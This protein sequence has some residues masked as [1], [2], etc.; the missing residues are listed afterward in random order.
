MTRRVAVTG[1]GVICSIGSTTAEFWAGCQ[2]GTSNV[3]P[4]PERWL[5]YADYKSRIWSPLPDIDYADRDLSRIEQLQ[6]DPV[7]MLALCASQEALL[8]AGL[9]LTIKDKRANSYTID[10]IDPERAGVFMGTGLGGSQSFL[11]SHC[12]LVLARSR[13]KLGAVAD[14]DDLEPDAR[15]TISDIVGRMIHPPRVHRFVV[16]M[17]MPN[18][19]AAMLGLKYTING[20]VVANCGACASGTVAIGNAFREVKSGTVDVALTG[21]AE[22][23]YDPYG[24]HFRC[25]DVAGT[26]VQNWDPPGQAN[27]PFDQARSGFLFSQGGAGVI[28]LEELQRALDRGAPILAEIVGYGETFDAHSIMSLDPKG[29]QIE[30][31][32]RAAISEAGLDPGDIQYINAHGT[33]TRNNDP[34]EA[35]VLKR[36]F[37]TAPLVNSTKSLLG[38]TIG[39][40]GALEAIVTA[41]TINTGTPHVCRNLDVP[42][43][44]INFVRSPRPADIAVGFTESFAFGGHN[45]GLVLRRVD[46]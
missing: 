1:T 27:R 3:A 35:E 21:G 8:N 28:V 19:V 41:L 4:I 26:L 38:H 2:R 36:V 42:V 24:Y 23:F 18:A 39:A 44:D 12:H 10:G 43:S 16:S 11:D 45:A 30:R 17:T 31:M 32:I 13:E 7:S 46:A 5:D 34:I 25:F 22:S 9:S 20:P 29:V 15:K 14:R 6:L 40:S 33:G 37:G